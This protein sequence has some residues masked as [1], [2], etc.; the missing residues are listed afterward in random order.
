MLENFYKNKKVLITGHSGF[1]G[2]WLSLWLS[3]LGAHV[4]GYSL[5]PQTNPAMFIELNISNYI[6]KSIEG[7]ILDNN[8][9]EKCF[10]EYKPE[11]VF[12]LAAQPL[13][14]QSYL[15]PVLTY[16]TNVIGTL[17]VL[18]SARK[19]ESVKQFVNITTDKCYENT[20]T[21]IGYKENDKLGGYDMYSS[22]KACSEI[23]SSSYRRSFLAENGFSLA[24]ARAGNV[25]GGG[26]WADDR[27]IPD[28]VK[29]I[30][31]NKEIEIRN[32]KSIRPWQFVL[33]PLF[34][35]LLLGKKLA[36]EPHKFSQAYN[37]GPNDESA[38]TVFDIVQKIQQY[39][40]NCK[41]KFTEKNNFLHEAKILTLNI[42]KT[43]EQLGW[44]PSLEVFEAIDKT[45]IW[46]KKFYEK[47]TNMFEFTISQIE[48]YEE[49]IK[50]NKSCAIK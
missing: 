36:D 41:V 24:T 2:S 8:K 43:K 32:P 19:C 45:L 27:L 4:I 14:K 22:S 23:L 26:D 40:N 25:I 16:K 12:H 50:W 35:Y 29:S 5:L 48:E 46:Y 21:K 20:E 49:K 15:D 28:C 6:H 9:L 10:W 11:I 42:E 31:A 7:D 39:S 1:K 13:V 47:N 3:K 30:A 44:Q 37:F 38:L 18:E 17:N 33:E 34:G